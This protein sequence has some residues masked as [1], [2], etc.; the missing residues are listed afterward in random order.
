MTQ[1]NHFLC[2]LILLNSFNGFVDM[3]A[4]SDL[5]CFQ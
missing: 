3:V 5:I 1:I 2:A 4:V